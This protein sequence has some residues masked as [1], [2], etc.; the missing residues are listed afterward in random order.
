MTRC[1]RV[2]DLRVSIFILLSV[3][4]SLHIQPIHC[5]VNVGGT[6]EQATPELWCVSLFSFPSNSNLTSLV[7][8]SSCVP[9]IKAAWLCIRTSDAGVLWNQSP[10]QSF[11]I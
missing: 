10:L 9:L 8:S 6:V 5:S 3:S 2:V 11:L 4:F 7:L 1:F